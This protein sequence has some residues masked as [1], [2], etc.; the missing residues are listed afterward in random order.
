MEITREEIRGYI[1]DI[2]ENEFKKDPALIVDTA[3]LENELGLDSLDFVDILFG[4][5]D[6]CGFKIFAEDL[7]G[8]EQVEG[9]DSR[10]ISVAIT[11]GDLVEAVYVYLSHKQDPHK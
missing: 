4:I 1:V 6:R 8:T 3:S 11:L 2:L 10:Q 9:M 5:E 7:M